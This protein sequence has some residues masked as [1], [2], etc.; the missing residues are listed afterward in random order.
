MTAAVAVAAPGA[1]LEL[2]TCWRSTPTVI[3]PEMVM[4][5]DEAAIRRDVEADFQKRATAALRD[6]TRTDVTT[7]FHLAPQDP[8]WG[9]IDRAA[10]QHA[11]LVVIGSHGRR[12]LKRWVL[13]SV[14]EATVR[15]ATC[16]VLV[17][18]EPVAH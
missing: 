3:D 16:S 11:D 8:P 5:I 14:A 4:A 6:V 13:G 12:G 2:V 15:H 9:V 7:S 17:A 1:S 10:S 18:R